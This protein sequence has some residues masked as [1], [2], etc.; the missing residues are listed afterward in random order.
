MST[1][2][3]LEPAAPPPQPA[4]TPAIQ[5]EVHIV[6]H[7][8]LFYWW[9]LWA[10]GLILGMLSFVEGRLVAV[11]PAGT[12]A[13]RKHVV[14]TGT[15]KDGHDT[16]ETREGY[17][18]PR[19]KHLLPDKPEDNLPDKPDEPHLRMTSHSS[20]GVL[21]ATVLL[22]IIVITNV[23]LRG[24]W[25]VVVIIMIVLISVI[26]ALLGWWD[27]I[28]EAVRL[29]DIRINAGGY[30]FI[31]LILLCIWLVT[32]VLFDRQIYMIFTPGQ[33][34]VCLEIGGGET[35]YDTSGMVIQKQRDDLFRHWI[36]GLGSGDLIVRTSG[37]NAHE[38]HLPNVLFV[39]RKLQMIEQMQRDRPVVKGAV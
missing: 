29:L 24:L 23:P 16:K 37:A 17:V 39:G 35:A 26:F 36:L 12:D 25:S 10:I 13:S 27:T 30:F 11:V 5:K 28:F 18:L 32:T 1:E 8:M 31:S 20:Y 2:P 15:D 21:W 9:P 7:S 4:Y 3:P 19:G 33:L 34:R 38:F 22:L 6:S 14:V